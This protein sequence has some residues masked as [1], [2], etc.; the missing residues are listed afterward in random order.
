M[1]FAHTL[2]Q[3]VQGGQSP[4]PPL[5]VE[6]IIPQEFQYMR[7]KRRSSHIGTRS[8]AYIKNNLKAKH[9]RYGMIFLL[10]SVILCYQ[11]SQLVIRFFEERTGISDEYM[12]I[13]KVPFP[14][15]NVCPK[16]PY[17][18]DV[19]KKHGIENRRQIQFEAQWVSN[20]SSITPREMY[21]YR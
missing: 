19:L 16:F 11:V 21:N 20:D 9:V 10:C 17:K 15:F 14:E 7:P 3:G 12:D 13:S 8:M 2:K 5:T 18:T 4:P 1:P 6:E